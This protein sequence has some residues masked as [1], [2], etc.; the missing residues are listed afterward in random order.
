M[1]TRAVFLGAGA[2]KTF[3]YPL[4]SEILPQIRRRLKNRSLFPIGGADSEA[5]GRAQA[6]RLRKLQNELDRSRLV[7]CHSGS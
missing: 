6:R 2:S 4:T 5:R 1:L 3:G 7:S